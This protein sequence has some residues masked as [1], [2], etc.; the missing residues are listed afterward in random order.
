[1]K[2]LKKTAV[3]FLLAAFCC[4]P[5]FA[6]T[7]RWTGKGETEKASDAKNW[8][9][10]KVPGKGDYVIFGQ[11]SSRNCEWDLAVTLYYFSMRREYK[12]NVRI[13]ARA[14]TITENMNIEGGMLDLQT[15]SLS[16]GR[17]LY[18]GRKGAFDLSNG[19]LTVGPTGILVDAGGTFLSTGEST[20]RIMSAKRNKYY[21]FVVGKGNIALSNP[22]GTE[23]S[24][25]QG[26]TLYSK[27][28][29][30]QADYV[31]VKQLKPGK[32]AVKVYAAPGKKKQAEVLELKGWTF[33]ETVKKQ[34][35]SQFA[36]LSPAPEPIPAGTAEAAAQQGQPGYTGAEAALT[37]GA[38]VPGTQTPGAARIETAIVG[39]LPVG[40]APLAV[41][42]EE[43]PFAA[44]E[45][46][47]KASARAKFQPYLAIQF[48]GGQHFFQSQQG[49]LSGNLNV[50]ASVAVKHE[51]LGPDWTLVP[52][53]SSQYQGTKQITDLVGGGTLFQERMSHSLALRSVHQMGPDWKFKPSIGYK[54]EFL[55]ETRDEDWGGGLF[56]YSR[57]GFSLELEHAYSD[58]FS[59]SFGYDFYHIGFVNYRSL[60]SIINDSQGNSMARE[61]AGESVL[62]SYNHSLSFFGTLKGPWRSYAEGGVAAT[63]RLFPDQHVV[64]RSG[65]YNYGT[66]RDLSSQLFAS[67]KFPRELSSS[68]KAVGGVRASL[69]NNSSNQ[70]SYD[71]Q[72]FK[73]LANYYD[74]LSFKAGVDLNFYR[75]LAKEDRPLELSFSATLGRM[76][77]N[78]RETQAASGLYRGSK[79]YQNEAV[80]GLGLSYPIAPHFRW[81]SQFGYGRQTSNQ[82]FEKLYKYNFSTTNY[83]FGFTYEY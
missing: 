65:S 8:R 57:P 53:L 62:N 80:V 44:M 40:A 70:N 24:G 28:K 33:D 51:K 73:Y 63:L 19:T 72:R 6:A 13:D 7:A 23:V 83:K 41:E 2:R 17:R 82:D 68:W 38:Q 32:S 29:V 11:L 79:V 69:G 30:L 39:T 34:S 78:G 22:A 76:N 16:V 74:S 47:E 67:L 27:A 9:S 58:P 77:Y 4:S 66:R 37:A 5:A 35:G 45:E 18:V 49:D 31:N 42:E 81:T 75:K 36:R 25:S 1:M 48:N 54:R 52:V 26:V 71:A 43:V 14:L 59:L 20:A 21:K 3:L 50:L 46:Y 55:K 12:G 60:E 56:D 61:L 15:A 64:A 10:G